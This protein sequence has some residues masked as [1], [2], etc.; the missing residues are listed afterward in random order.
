MPR[1][2]HLTPSLLDQEEQFKYRLNDAT[3]TQ[4]ILSASLP[5]LS[6]EK[7]LVLLYMQR[8]YV[9]LFAVIGAVTVL[10][11]VWFVSV[12]LTK[13]P[14]KNSST[15]AQNISELPSNLTNSVTA[16]NADAH[17]CDQDMV[18]FCKGTARGKQNMINCLLG[19]YKDEISDECR[20]SLERRQ[21]LNENLLVAC[22]DDRKK[23][24]QGVEPALGSA[25]LDDCLRVHVTDLSPACALAFQ[26]HEAAKPTQ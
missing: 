17:S 19:E 4:I 5:V 23:F 13:E 24:C 2:A 12:T 15:G 1:H 3:S 18:T 9:T 22:E 21:Q 20:E 8:L 25:P 26:Q 6:R 11:V 16:D 14:L 7:L 10:S